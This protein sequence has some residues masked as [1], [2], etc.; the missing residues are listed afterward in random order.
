MM[1]PRMST[2][3]EHT[4]AR[5]HTFLRD[6]CWNRRN[7]EMISE[8]LLLAEGA[9]THLVVGCSLELLRPSLHVNVSVFYICLDAIC[10]SRARVCQAGREDRSPAQKEAGPNRPEQEPGDNQDRA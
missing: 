3:T 1:I 8:R 6:F 9:A 2:A 5:T 10:T 7:E 4:K